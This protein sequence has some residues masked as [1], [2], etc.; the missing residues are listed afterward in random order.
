MIVSDPPPFCGATDVA[1]RSEE[2]LRL[3]HR[4]RIESARQGAAGAALRGVVR[5]RHAR[6]R[7]EHDHDVLAEF[8]EPV[9]ALEHHFAHFDVPF[10]RLVEARRDHFADAPRDRFAHFFRPFVD[11]ENEQHGLGVIDRHAF[12]D[13]VEQRRLAGACRGDDECA[14]SVADWRD[15][16]DRAARQLVAD[17]GGA[18]GLERETPLGVRRRERNE[19]GAAFAFRRKGSPLIVA[20]S[21]TVIR[22]RWSLPARASI[23]SPRRSP[24]CR[25][26]FGGTHGSPGTAR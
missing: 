18:S 1:R 10:R 26:R 13:G 24:Y 5:A 20:I 22:P 25:I 3:R 23:R 21:A 19:I 2:R 9:R 11:Q 12:G 17:F 4:G 16:V 15:Q 8:H 6:E 7:I 14:L